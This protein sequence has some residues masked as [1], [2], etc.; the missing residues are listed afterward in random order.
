MP[1]IKL[2]AF[3]IVG[4]WPY[5]AY[6]MYSHWLAYRLAWG[7]SRKRF[8]R[9][10]HRAT[11][12]R[13]SPF[14]RAVLQGFYCFSL[15]PAVQRE[16]RAH[17]VRGIGAPVLLAVLFG[18]LMPL[19]TAVAEPLVVKAFLSPAWALVPVQLGINRLNRSAGV[20]PRFGVR[21]IELV[22]VALGLIV[23]WL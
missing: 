7:Y 19:L 5:F 3:G 17:R 15:F 14:W 10:V 11:G 21:A 20:E 18:W 16:C 9:R 22:F 2:L 23:S 1:I 12:Y 6:W 4:G 13:V 8:W